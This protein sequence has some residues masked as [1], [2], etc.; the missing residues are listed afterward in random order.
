[1]FVS[2]DTQGIESPQWLQV[3]H[4]V[5]RVIPGTFGE[6]TSFG[7]QP[8]GSYVEDYPTATVTMPREEERFT[9]GA[10]VIVKGKT[11]DLEHCIDNAAKSLG[12]TGEES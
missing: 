11:P 6:P 4:E 1:M 12:F 9:P 7:T 10:T 3:I 8:D 5:N 2:K